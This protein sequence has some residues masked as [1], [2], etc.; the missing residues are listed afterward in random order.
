MVA[1][2]LW[3]VVFDRFIISCKNSL[4]SIHSY[5]KSSTNGD[6]YPNLLSIDTSS[7][8]LKQPKNAKV[9]IDQYAIVSKSFGKIA[10]MFINCWIVIGDFL[11]GADDW[12]SNDFNASLIRGVLLGGG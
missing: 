11:L 12:S 1:V 8:A 9:V 7:P 4:P 3:I 6:L 5:V 2:K 10:I